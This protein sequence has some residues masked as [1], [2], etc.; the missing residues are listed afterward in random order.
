MD[1]QQPAV[2]RLATLAGQLQLKTTTMQRPSFS[3]DAL[4][5]MLDHDNL[6]MRAS[7]KEFMKDPIYVP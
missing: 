1:P 5:R 6:E 2:R 4:N 3:V 7:M